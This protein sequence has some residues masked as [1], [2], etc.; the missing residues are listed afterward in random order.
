[1]DLRFDWTVDVFPSG[2]ATSDGFGRG[3]NLDVCLGN[4]VLDPFLWSF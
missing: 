2:K 4:K 1:L 3:N